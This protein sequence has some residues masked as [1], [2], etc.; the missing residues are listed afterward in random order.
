[1]LGKKILSTFIHKATKIKYVRKDENT[2]LG[3]EEILEKQLILD[4][5]TAFRPNLTTTGRVFDYVK[6]VVVEDRIDSGYYDGKY[7]WDETDIYH[8]EKYNMPINQE[9]IEYVLSK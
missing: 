8:L 9:F 4:Y 6:N 3:V 1:M 5:L 2:F 7:Y